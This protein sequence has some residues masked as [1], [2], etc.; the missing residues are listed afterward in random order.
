MWANPYFFRFAWGVTP[1]ATGIALTVGAVAATLRYDETDDGRWFGLALVLIVLG[2]ANHGWEATVA[3]PVAAIAVH[4]GEWLHGV[5][6]FAVAGVAL[7]VVKTIVGLQPNGA[8]TTGY[9]LG[10][11][12]SFLLLSPDWWGYWAAPLLA[13]PTGPFSLARPVLFFGGL[14]AAA[15]SG[16]RVLRRRRRADVVV[17]AWLF[18]GLAV[19]FGLPGGAVIHYYYLW[20]VVA[21]L[22]VALAAVGGRIHATLVETSGLD[23]RTV[24]SVVLVVVVAVG[25]VNAVWTGVRPTVATD[26]DGVG[27]EYRVDT[28]PDDLRP[29]EGERAGRAIRRA[30]VA[31][32]GSIVFVGNWTGWIDGYGD[33]Y[34]SGAVRVMVYSGTVVRGVWHREPVSDRTTVPRF[35]A[36]NASV[37]DCS[38]TVHRSE[39]GNASVRRCGG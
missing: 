1:E 32:A 22:T 28:T 27:V 7:A 13:F 12:E 37:G 5:G 20:G 25:C 21:P 14:V 19:P 16:Y 4:R 35:V 8:E 17:F 2:I 15:V 11:S 3:L 23:A 6:A 29:G 31:D 34:R 36:S 39:T 38:V 18:S 10:R 33:Y 26:G 24:L 9:L 30:G